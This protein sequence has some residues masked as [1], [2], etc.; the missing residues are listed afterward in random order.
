MPSRRLLA[1]A[2]AAVVLLAGC[3]AVP[4]FG[5]GS[6]G[7]GDAPDGPTAHG[8]A[9]ESATGGVPFEG[10]V[11]VGKDGETLVSRNVSSDGDGTFVDVATLNQSGPFT[12]TVNT[13]IPGVGGGTMSERLT[14]PGALGCETVVD[15]SYTRIRARTVSL[16]RQT[17]ETDLQFRKPRPVEIRGEDT[18]GVVVQYQGETIVDAAFDEDSTGPVTVGALDRTGFYRIRFRSGDEWSNRTVVVRDPGTRVM[19]EISRGPQI[20]VYGPDEPIPPL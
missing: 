20:S 3:A 18:Y 5:G 9:F 8:I 14:V 6:D 1:A 4:G 7:N 19:L 12:V 10:T 15:L 2:L 16:P 13:T 17:V 11:A